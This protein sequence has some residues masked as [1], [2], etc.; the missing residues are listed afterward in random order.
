VEISKTASVLSPAAGVTETYTLQLVIAGGNANGIQ[1]SDPIPAGLTYVSSGAPTLGSVVYNAGTTQLG[2]S[3]PANSAPGTYTCSFQASVDASTTCGAIVNTAY[4]TYTGFVGQKTANAPISTTCPYTVHIGVYNEAGELV[5]LLPVQQAAQAI[6]NI[7]LPNNSI[8][9]LKGAGNTIPIYFGGVLIGTWDGTNNNGNLVSNGTYHI[10]I[11]N[12]DSQGVVTNVSQM[13]SVDRHLIRVGT[14]IYNAAGEIIRHLYTYVDDPAGAVLTN[15]TT[16]SDRID[17][18][19]TSPLQIVLQNTGAPITMTWDGT[20]DSGSNA[21]PGHYQ[22]EVH[23]DDGAGGTSDISRGLL[24]VSDVHPGDPIIAK[25]NILNA[26]NGFQTTFLDTLNPTLILSY[27]A[28]TL[29][30]ELAD[31][32]DGP[33]GGGN[34]IWDA[35]SMASGVYIAVVDARNSSGGLVQRSTLKVLVIH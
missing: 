15:V 3:L 1:V 10:K 6:L 21:T 28:Y 4:L 23:W 33:A 17:P 2:W 35:S 24:V 5:K 27:K 12:V 34:L 26:Q 16:S 18:G 31:F 7:T 25:P 13:V 14:D 22:M 32:K 9:S 8:T 29:A 19:V 20:T 30:G 11:D